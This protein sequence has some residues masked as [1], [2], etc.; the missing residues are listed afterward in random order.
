MSAPESGPPASIMR[1]SP[2]IGNTASEA[3]YRC[4]DPVTPIVAAWPF[5]DRQVTAVS[6]VELPP[7]VGPASYQLTIPVGFSPAGP[8][9]A[10][11]LESSVRSQV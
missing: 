10:W 1:T 5:T 4:R 3:P 8:L 6:E 7:G 11:R 2:A 9:T